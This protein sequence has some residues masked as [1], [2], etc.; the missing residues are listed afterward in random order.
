MNSSLLI[1]VDNG[2]PT[3]QTPWIVLQVLAC[4][5]KHPLNESQAQQPV[6]NLPQPI[7]RAEA[8]L[9]EAE[10]APAELAN[11]TRI[12]PASESDPL[13]GPW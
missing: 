6:H 10:G 12:T 11:E 5:C 2:Q 1:G 8:A 3:P 7:N 4:S 13:Y 9:T